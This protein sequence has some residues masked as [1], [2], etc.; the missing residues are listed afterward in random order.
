MLESYAANG[1]GTVRGVK[2]RDKEVQIEFWRRAAKEGFT[3]ERARAS[4]HKFRVAFDALE[5]RLAQHPYLIGRQFERARHRLVGVSPTGC[6]LG[7]YPFARLHPPVAAWMATSARPEF[8]KEIAM[9]PEAVTR[10][11]ATRRSQVEA[12]KRLEVVAGF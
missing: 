1:T 5:Q 12:G 7:G 9:P 2:D 10:L 4:A 11:E 6:R 3:D 8:A